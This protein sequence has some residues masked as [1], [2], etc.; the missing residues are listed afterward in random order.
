MS[1]P[2][3][4]SE[5][6]GHDTKDGLERFLIKQVHPAMLAEAGPTC[7]PEK[8]LRCLL[9]TL[10]GKIAAS[11]GLSDAALP[12]PPYR[13]KTPILRNLPS[14]I[15]SAVRITIL[16]D[17]YSVLMTGRHQRG[18][19]YTPPTLT[20]T[21][22]RLVIDP[23]TPATRIIDPAM[24]SG[25]FLLAAAEVIVRSIEAGNPHQS[26]AQIRWQALAQLHGIDIDPMAVELAAIS[27]WLWAACPGTTPAML[28]GR[29]VCGD[30]LLDD[31][32]WQNMPVLPFDA[33]IGNPPYASAITRARARSTP[34]ATLQHRYPT[35]RGSFDLCVPFVECAIGLC[36][37][38]GRCGLVLPNKLLAAE[39][40]RP[41]RVWLTETVTVEAIIDASQQ[42]LFKTGVYPVA[43]IFRNTPPSPDQ[44]LSI[45]R[46]SMMPHAGPSTPRQAD[47][48]SAPRHSWSA[49][50]DPGWDMLRHC[51]RKAVPL[52]ELATLA[53]GLAVAEAYSLRPAIFDAPED[54]LPE[55]AFCLLTSGLIRR[56]TTT[57]G[58]TAATYLKTAYQRPAVRAA[59]L[60]TRRR[61]Q[62][63]APKLIVAGMGKTPRAVVDHGQAQASVATTIILDTVWPLD[64]LC[65]LLNS[66]LVGRLCQAIFGG[67]ALG[68]GHLRFG[69][70]EMAC[71]PLPPVDP[72]DPRL[73]RLD[74]MASVRASLTTIDA[75]QPAEAAIEALVCDLYEVDGKYVIREA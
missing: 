50:I 73:G 46:Q 72:L 27:L 22:A 7:S 25:H 40:A 6:F 57:W 66:Q 62:A 51:W 35:A 24:G 31:S 15:L 55:D 34:Q 13:A 28:A 71:I 26:D 63:A 70:P 3:N 11:K 41:L 23:S 19:Y 67:L 14:E 29:L 61:K 12:P 52:G 56:Y 48:N 53:S 42:N 37:P 47:L 75:I 38:G 69:K 9:F 45:Y 16:G 10:A 54:G 65:A 36:R 68:G 4:Y 44:P 59:S 49:I 60:P 21:V 64:A 20:E 8:V 58:Q 39:Y 33:V 74:E 43:A 5:R 1:S 2:E 32:C 18:S 17:I 30:A